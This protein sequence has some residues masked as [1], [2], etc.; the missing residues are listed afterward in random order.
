MGLHLCHVD[1]VLL[2]IA[3]FAPLLCAISIHW[4]EIMGGL[5]GENDKNGWL[6]E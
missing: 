4:V 1:G 5:L 6:T 2:L 3:F